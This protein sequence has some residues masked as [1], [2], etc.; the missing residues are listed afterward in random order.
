MLGRRHPGNT[1]GGGGGGGGGNK[2]DEHIINYISGTCVMVKR[3]R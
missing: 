3:A 2:H 1:W